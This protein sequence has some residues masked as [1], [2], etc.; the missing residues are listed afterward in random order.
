MAL[1]AMA[2]RNDIPSGTDWRAGVWAGIIGW[3]LYELVQ[4]GWALAQGT[5][6][7]MLSRLSAA[8][9]LGEPVASAPATFEPAIVI[10]GSLIHLALSIVCGLIVAWLVHRFNWTVGLAVGA[11]YGFA[12]YLIYYYVISPAAFPW[13]VAMRG[14][15]MGI[16]HVL[17]GVAVAAAYL[18]L[19]KEPS[20]PES[21]LRRA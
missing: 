2:P 10:A 4:T 20:A 18:I 15:T 7:W 17:Y 14:W 21:D 12:I 16:M 13:F 3:V 5:S 9:V 19:R 1:T 6:P 8:M 11:V